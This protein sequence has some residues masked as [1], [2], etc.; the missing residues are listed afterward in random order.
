MLF[1]SPFAPE[2][3]REAVQTISSREALCEDGNADFRSLIELAKRHV[4][5]KA[6]S[7]A[8]RIAV[9]AIA[10]EAGNPEGYYLL[11]VLNEIRGDLQEAQKFYRAALS[12][13]PAHAA[14]SANLHRIT[15]WET[16]D[17]FNQGG[18][19]VE[20]GEQGTGT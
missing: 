7:E 10:R 8:A 18:Y 19:Y 1:R 17:V 4:A 14:A 20:P 12:F 6:F 13:D 15:T 16:H 5:D 3:L 11:G 2:Q 9:K